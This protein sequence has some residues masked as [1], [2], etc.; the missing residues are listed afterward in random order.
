[1][2]A[3]KR[4]LG[5]GL[6]A[7]LSS[8]KPAPS[9]RTEQPNVSE[10]DVIIQP[11]SSELQKLPIEF[12]HSGK[13][14]PRKDMSEEALEELASSI[15]SQGIIQPIVVRPVAEN[16]YEIIAGERRWRAA[17]IAK[18]DVVP[19]IIKDVPDEAAVAIALIENI[20]RE[21]LNAM[22]EAV[23]LHRLLT[24]FELT[25]QQVADAVGK[26]RTTVTN[27]LRLN[28]LNDDVKILLEH[29]DIEMGHARCLLAL[30]GE[31]Q[32][33]AARLAVAKALTVRET[34][35]LVRSIIEPAPKKETFEKDPDV[36]QLEQQLAENLGAKVEINYNKKGKGNLVISYT[37]LEELD[38]IL[39]RINAENSEH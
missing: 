10:Q 9:A 26:S 5:R 20:Q 22:E 23:A 8:S 33:D 2:S 31:A 15:R 35:K 3:K 32:S 4:G 13:Y 17:Q 30:E 27:L 18:L 12:L 36:K 21:D 6:D 1:M 25:H 19:C 14:Q 24:E 7:L 39:S 29:G 28:N 38:G 37:N 16:S 11:T 34:E